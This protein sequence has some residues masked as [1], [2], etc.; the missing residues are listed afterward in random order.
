MLFTAVNLWEKNFTS[1]KHHSVDCLYFT[2]R[3][4]SLFLIFLKSKK[5]TLP[6]KFFGCS[7]KCRLGHQVILFP[8][9]SSFFQIRANILT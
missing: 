7:V 4:F 1:L 8:R 9:L 3:F 6:G 2:F 5:L